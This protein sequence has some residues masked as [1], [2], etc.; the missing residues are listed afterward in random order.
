LDRN[1]ARS[2]SLTDE[3]SSIQSNLEKSEYDHLQQIQKQNAQIEVAGMIARE[4]AAQKDPASLVTSTINLIHDNFGFYHVGVFVLDETGEFAVL[5]AA[6]G[7][8]GAKLIDA[9]HRLRVGEEGIVGSAIQL[10]KAHIAMDVGVDAV[11]FDNPML[12]ETRSE[13]AIPLSAG[14]KAFGALDIQSKDEAAF[15]TQ[16]IKILQIIADQLAIAM[17]R[18]DLVTKFQQASD[19]LRT[20]YQTFTQTA[21]Q[22]F[23]KRGGKVHS[24]QLEKGNEK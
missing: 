2:K 4:I 23:L 1:F 10:G 6:T 7:D 17:D 15:S 21:W 18:A 14:G 12:P 9:H 13:M 3:F 24:V 22:S 19:E 8:A 11:H 20:S 5:K 16:D